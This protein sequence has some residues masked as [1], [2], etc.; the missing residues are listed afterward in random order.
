[1][2]ILK[3]I[4][5]TS[6]QKEILVNENFNSVSPL[7]LFSIRE[8][9]NGITVFIRGGYY[10]NNIGTSIVVLD[11]K[12][13]VSVSATTYVYFNT[14]T[15]IIDSNTTGFTNGNIP[16]YTIITNST[17][18]TSIVDNRKVAL[19]KQE[20]PNNFY[21]APYVL[22]VA[23]STTVGAVKPDGGTIVVDGFGTLTDVTNPSAAIVFNSTL[24]S[25]VSMITTNVAVDLIDMTL[26]EGTYYLIYFATF[27]YSS[28]SNSNVITLY[29]SD[30]TNIVSHSQ[31][32]TFSTTSN[33]NRHIQNSNACVITLTE[34]K[35]IKLRAMHTFSS[36][37]TAKALATTNTL[38]GT[39]GATRLIALKI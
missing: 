2:T 10:N 5:R 17:K 14:N 36:T 1:M 13:N 35:T 12:F 33:P 25:D 18:I 32:S 4:L 37:A 27:L 19:F 8:N 6:K 24:T 30:G 7:G 21:V 22:P 28:P 39:D 3:P 38:Y 23:T 9:L 11:K 16:L 26:T 31:K 15:N 29:L 34:T 20:T